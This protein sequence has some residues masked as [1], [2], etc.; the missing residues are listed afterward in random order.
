MTRLPSVQ[1]MSVLPS[2]RRMAV[3][4]MFGVFTLPD[5]LALRRV[6]ADDLV[7]QLRH[8]VVAVG[9]LAGHAGLQMMVLRLSLERDF[10]EDLALAIDFQQARLV[11]GLGE[12]DLPLRRAAGRC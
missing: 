10:D 2:S 9:Q 1:P 4:G 12:Q 8:Q 6:L 3:N 11:A 7:E 5:D